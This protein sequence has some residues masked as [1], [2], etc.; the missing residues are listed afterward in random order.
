MLD[1]THYRSKLRVPGHVSEKFAYFL[2]VLLG[3][4]SVGSERR[5]T[6]YVVGD[7]IEERGFYDNFLIPLI[8]S[9]FRINPYA[10]ERKGKLAYAVHFKSKRLVEYLVSKLDFP[11]GGIH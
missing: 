11:N 4:G 9:L 5:P 1:R 3:D 2:G 10:Y 7:L 6:I 8:R